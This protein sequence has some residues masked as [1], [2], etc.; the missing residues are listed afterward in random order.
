MVLAV[1]PGRRKCGVAVV[2]PEG[3]LARRVVARE[4]TVALVRQWYYRYHAEQ[5]LVGG[6]TASREVVQEIAKEL[7]LTPTVVDERFS[8]ERARRRYFVDNPPRGLWRLIP[9]GLRVPPVAVDDY[10][11]VVLAEDFLRRASGVAEGSPQDAIDGRRAKHQAP[12]SVAKGVS[13]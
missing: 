3:I 10:A 9:L 12:Q 1:D 6:A 13:E 4:E 7:D 2:G 8:T 5:C 11:A